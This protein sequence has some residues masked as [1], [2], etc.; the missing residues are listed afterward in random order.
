MFC[1]TQKSCNYIPHEKIF[2]SALNF[3]TVCF[4]DSE[5]HIVSNLRAFY[6]LNIFLVVS[7][8]FFGKL[9]FFLFHIQK[10]TIGLRSVGF[11]ENR[12]HFQIPLYTSH[13]C[14]TANWIRINLENCFHNNKSPWHFFSSPSMKSYH[15]SWF[16]SCFA[17]IWYCKMRFF[18][19]KS[20]KYIVK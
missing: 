6:W 9:T 2:L 18:I 20:I 16:Y 17:A 11:V 7:V 1:L 12:R 10:K 4:V 5:C 8:F 3:S 13:S 14:S 19:V 15:I